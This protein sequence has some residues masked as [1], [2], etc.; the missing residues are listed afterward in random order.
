MAADALV[1]EVAHNAGDGVFFVRIHRAA[2]E[3]RR[4]D[5]VMTGGGHVL[6]HRQLGR[7]TMQQTDVAPQF[8]LFESIKTVACR[9]TRFAAGARVEV[10]FKRIL[11]ASARSRRGDQITVIL[12]LER[13]TSAGVI[14]RK[15]VDR[16]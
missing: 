8:V 13:N 16:R 3:A 15:P 7:T 6:Q 12:R 2:I 5:A 14:L 4:L 11:L 9:Y 1:V 10:D